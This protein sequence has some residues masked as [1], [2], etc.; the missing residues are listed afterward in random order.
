MKYAASVL[1]IATLFAAGAQAK[2]TKPVWQATRTSDPITGKT[3]CVVAAYDQAAGMSFTRI[4][5]LYPIVEINS[6][7]GV[8]V[9]VSS[10]GQFRIPAG[11]IIWRVDDLPYRE[12]R[13]ADNPAGQAN[14]HSTGSVE[15]A[16]EN[17][18][19][20]TKSLIATSTVASGDKAKAMLEELRTG[21]S[22]QF[23][24]AGASTGY[25]LPG[26]AMYR[27]GRMTKDGLVP[28]PLDVSFRAALEQC[29]M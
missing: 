18:L 28:Y 10:G 21:R 15:Q 20:L 14:N 19:A 13:A 25:G 4:G 6:E 27:T 29:G 23:R 22:L 12:L 3:S 2:K 26:D 8:L 11:D 5:A 1:A 7:Y 16:N 17:V 24:R 9:G